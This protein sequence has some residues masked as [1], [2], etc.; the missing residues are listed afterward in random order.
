M[1]AIHACTPFALALVDETVNRLL[2]DV[3][4][5]GVLEQLQVR[6]GAPAVAMEQLDFVFEGV[7][8]IF[9]NV[10]AEVVVIIP[11]VLLIQ[12]MIRYLTEFVVVQVSNVNPQ[13]LEHE[14]SSLHHF[15]EVLLVVLL[16]SVLHFY[17]ECV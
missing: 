9:V 6:V 13:I 1:R 15:L 5:A 10:L 3:V 16:I 7:H 12:N 17:C 4:S 11:H 14:V 8:G 2:G